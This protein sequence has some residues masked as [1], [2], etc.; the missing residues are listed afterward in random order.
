MPILE[1]Q[2]VTV[3]FGG[4]IALKGVTMDIAAGEIRGLI[5]PNG[6]GKSTLFNVL[7][8]LTRLSGAASCSRETTCWRSARTRSRRGASRG[9]SRP[10]TSSTA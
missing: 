6:A 7:S 8:G 9:P 2:E 10:R 1:I 5:G 3:A 4:L